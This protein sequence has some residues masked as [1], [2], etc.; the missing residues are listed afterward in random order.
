MAL[1]L[2]YTMTEMAAMTGHHPQ[3]IRKYC[4]EGLIPAE[5]TGTRWRFRKPVIDRWLAEQRQ[6]GEAA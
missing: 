2:L 1:K 5:W 3:T 4:R 6:D